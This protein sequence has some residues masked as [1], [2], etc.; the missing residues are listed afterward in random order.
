MERRGRD[1]VLSP[2]LGLALLGKLRDFLF[3]PY[4][5]RSAETIRLG[6]RL[7]DVRPVGDAIQEGFAQARIRKHLRPFRERVSSDRGTSRTGSLDRYHEP[8]DKS[9]CRKC[10]SRLPRIASELCRLQVRVAGD[11]IHLES[12]DK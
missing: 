11:V 1:G 7:D 10:S 8:A 2:F 3:L 4:L 6:S 5:Q 9:A 12:T